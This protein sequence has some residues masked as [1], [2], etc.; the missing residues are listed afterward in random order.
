M[1]LLTAYFSDDI[2]AV[3]YGER[4]K[5]SNMIRLSRRSQKIDQANGQ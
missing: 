4:V 5:S 1:S 2:K 3:E